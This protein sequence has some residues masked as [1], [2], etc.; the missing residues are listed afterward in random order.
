MGKVDKIQYLKEMVWE[1]LT[2]NHSYVSREG[3]RTVDS[4][5]QVKGMECDRLI[6]I[7]IFKRGYAKCF[8]NQT[9]FQEIILE[10]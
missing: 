6:V 9:W 7:F 8:D 1:R 3:M 4:K 5:T 10:N 2:E